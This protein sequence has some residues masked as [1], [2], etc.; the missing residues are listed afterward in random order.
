LESSLSFSSS[1][2]IDRLMAFE[3]GITTT[4]NP[5]FH[6]SLFYRPES[7]LKMRTCCSPTESRQG[8]S[9]HRILKYA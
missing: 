1:V 9:N 3:T 4:S 8:A 5:Q 7:V 2:K 6:L